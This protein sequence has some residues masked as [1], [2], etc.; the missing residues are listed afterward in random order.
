MTLE[1]KEN[2]VMF[3][4]LINYEDEE[5]EKENNKLKR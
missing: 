3:V 1:V 4:I 5:K 2:K